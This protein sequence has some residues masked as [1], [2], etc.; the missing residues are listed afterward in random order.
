MSL[1]D[2]AVEAYA[3][4]DVE[5][6][7]LELQDRY[8]QSVPLL[9]WGLWVISQRHPLGPKA[10]RQGVNLARSWEQTVVGPLRQVRRTLKTSIDRIGAARQLELRHC[11]SEAELHAERVLFDALADLASA[12]AG[13]GPTLKG[14]DPLVKAWGQPAPAALLG[15]LTRSAQ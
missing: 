15:V 2:F 8:G 4:P 5:A 7:C 10:V 14:L 1:W 3:W 13:A 9:M 11:V 12:A 6:A